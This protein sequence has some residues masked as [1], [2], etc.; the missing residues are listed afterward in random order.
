MLRGTEVSREWGESADFTTLHHTTKV[1][2]DTNAPPCLQIQGTGSIFAPLYEHCVQRSADSSIDSDP[3]CNILGE[4]Y[5]HPLLRA[6][7][8]VW[9]EK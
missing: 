9:V 2:T 5:S 6:R 4:V 1:A 3:R 8:K 7:G